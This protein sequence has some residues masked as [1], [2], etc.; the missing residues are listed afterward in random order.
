MARQSLGKLGNDRVFLRYSLGRG[1]ERC[2]AEPE[3]RGLPPHHSAVTQLEAAG[4]DFG[5]QGSLPGTAFSFEEV[6]ARTPGVPSTGAG[7]LQGTVNTG[8]PR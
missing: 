3:R 7:P 6:S 4:F 1:G 5:K 8:A 2:N